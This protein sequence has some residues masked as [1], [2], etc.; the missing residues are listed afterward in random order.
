MER[1][2]K[3][4][5]QMRLAYFSGNMANRCYFQE[6]WPNYMIFSVLYLFWGFVLL[7]ERPDKALLRA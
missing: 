4:L 1:A 5:E 7:F 6:Q 2:K 3:K